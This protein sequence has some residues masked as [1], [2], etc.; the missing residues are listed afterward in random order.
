VSKSQNPW[1]NTGEK[2]D[3]GH[4]IY[5]LEQPDPGPAKPNPEFCCYSLR[6]NWDQVPATTIIDCGRVG[7]VPACQPCADFYERMSSS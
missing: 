7:V 6:H 1:K 5:E 3:S 4:V 2:T